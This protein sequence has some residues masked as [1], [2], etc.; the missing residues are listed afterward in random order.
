A[1]LH[2]AARP[3]RERV[4]ERH[5]G[6]AQAG[7]VR[8]QPGIHVRDAVSAANHAIRSGNTSIR[9]AAASSDWSARPP[10]GASKLTLLGTFR[11]YASARTWR[12]AMLNR[13]AVAARVAFL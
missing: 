2:V 9:T 1:Q 12:G 13:F 10:V 8:R 4:P 5:Y 11:P 7:E 6:R 3:R